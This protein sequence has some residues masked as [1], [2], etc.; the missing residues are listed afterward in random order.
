MRR[1][2]QLWFML[3]FSGFY[4]ILIAAVFKLFGETKGID[5]YTL[6]VAG[7]FG[8]VLNGASRIFWAVL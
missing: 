3:F 7:A 4:G 6:S 1:F 2:Y 8:A 5:D